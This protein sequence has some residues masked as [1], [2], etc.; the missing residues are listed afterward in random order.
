MPE[1]FD[2]NRENDDNIFIK[3]TKEDRMIDE[4]KDFPP[5]VVKKLENKYGPVVYKKISAVGIGLAKKEGELGEN[6]QYRGFELIG[7]C[8]KINAYTNEKGELAL[9]SHAY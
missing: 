8:R 1:I 3:F 5:E 7:E 9:I 6:F 2:K 4:S